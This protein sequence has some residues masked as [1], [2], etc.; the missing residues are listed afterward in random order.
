MASI[1][2]WN[3]TQW[4]QLFFLY[5]KVWN[6]SAWVRVNPKVWNGS[7]WVDVALL[8]TQTV[9]VGLSLAT[10]YGFGSGFGSIAPGTSAIYPAKS[11]TS[12][13]YNITNSSLTMTVPFAP[14]SGWTYMYV[15]TPSPAT[16]LMRASAVY[17]SSGT[18]SWSLAA[19]PF[20]GIGTTKVFTFY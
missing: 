18:W 2:V 13:Y 5:P 14:N 4:Q 11:I 16:K 3:G 9:T 20:G 6:G 19:N 15:G 12:L 1:Q 10:L 7:S 17:G 8:D